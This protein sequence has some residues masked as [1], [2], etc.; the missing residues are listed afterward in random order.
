MNYVTGEAVKL[1]DRV[2]LGQESDG[3]VV[4][5]IDTG[6]YSSD[7]PEAQWGGYLKKGVMI[8]FNSYGLFHYEDSIEPDVQLIARAESPPA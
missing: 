1:G 4:F 7:Y 5:I 6:E 2:R 8:H 3:V